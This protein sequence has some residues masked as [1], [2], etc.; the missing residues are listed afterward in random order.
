[1]SSRS[2]SH[3]KQ[4]ILTY[5]L[6]PIAKTLLLISISGYVLFALVFSQ[7]PLYAQ[8]TDA[9]ITA[10]DFNSAVGK[11]AAGYSDWTVRI[12]DAETG[13]LHHTMQPPDIPRDPASALYATS[14]L[15]F[16]P[17]G[18]KLAVSFKGDVSRNLIIILDTST[19]ETLLEISGIPDITTLDWSPDGNFLAGVYVYNPLTRSRSYLAVWNTETGEELNQ[20]ELSEASSLSLDWHP[21]ESRLAYT[22]STQVVVWDVDK[23][24]EEYTLTADE[25]GTTSVAWNPTGDRL[26]SVGAE[27]VVRIWNSETGELETEIRTDNTEKSYP[28]VFWNTDGSFVGINHGKRIKIWDASTGALTF[29]D[30]TPEIITG[31]ILKPDG[32][33]LYSS[34]DIETLE[35]TLPDF[36]GK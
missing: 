11:Y 28:N 17:N 21:V 27:G 1:M 24:Q 31:I 7:K 10:L 29:S 22:A 25:I 5:F 15:V 33:I 4:I 6:R 13:K 2:L 34:K 16:S 35:T 12:W 32:D 26:A 19:G 20:H 8:E 18:D 36:S 23:W 14:S 3:L 9:Y 30:E